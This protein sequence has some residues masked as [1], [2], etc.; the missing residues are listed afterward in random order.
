MDSSRLARFR[1]GFVDYLPLALVI[2]SYG[3]VFGALAVRSGLSVAESCLM[4]LTV[5]AGASQFMA[6]PLIREGAAA[7]T[8]VLMALLVNLRHLLYGLAIGRMFPRAGL[9]RLL[10]ISFG[11]V[12]ENYAFVTLGPGRERATPAYFLGTGL[13]TYVSWNLATLLGALLGA[14]VR[15]LDLAGLDFAAVAVFVA[16]VGSSLRSGRD[17]MV[18][19]GAASLAW[20]VKASAGGSWHVLAAGVLV[21]LVSAS[22]GGARRAAA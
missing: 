6:L 8:L 21:P 10:V 17:W 13:G 16:L 12:D 20:L 3:V 9:L 11:I 2:A 19:A 15:S 7:W 22:L 14:G 5:F 1:R 18:A 4:S